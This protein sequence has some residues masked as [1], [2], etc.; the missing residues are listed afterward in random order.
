MYGRV[1]RLEA[2]PEEMESGVA[3]V[4]DTIVPAAR[5]LDGF[6]GA[7]NFTDRQSGTG[8]TI[9]LWESEEAMRASEERANTLRDDAARAL[10]ATVVGVERYEV[11]IEERV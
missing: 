3:Y 8:M 5:E 6:R 9:T 4:R 10:G 1:T 2:S 7:L 11:T